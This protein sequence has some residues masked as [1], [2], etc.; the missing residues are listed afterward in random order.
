MSEQLVAQIPSRPDANPS[1]RP[2]ANPPS[3]PVANSA[4][5]STTSPSPT[6]TD[7]DALVEIDQMGDESLAPPPPRMHTLQMDE[8]QFTFL[9]SSVDLVLSSQS[10]HWVN[11]L[12]SLFKQVHRALK[13]D[14][15]FMFAMFGPETLFELRGALQLAE[16]ERRGGFGTHIS[17]FTEPADVS[18]FV[19]LIN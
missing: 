3:R 8:E 11:D 12:R 18:F 16:L 13:S 10:F 15:A 4:T 5:T 9:D 2:L 6:A 17:P 19:L 1:F 14:G 7:E